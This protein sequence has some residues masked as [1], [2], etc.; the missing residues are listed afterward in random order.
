MMDNIVLIGGGGHCKSVI[1][2]LI[3]QDRYKIAAI[4]DRSENLGIK[5]CGIPIN[6]TDDDLRSLFKS[7]I[8]HAFITVGGL[9]DF[10]IRE[11]LYHKAIEIGFEFP[12]IAD[13][14]AV[15]SKFTI[16]ESG[17][18]IGKMCVV[19]SDAKIR[20]MA[21]VNTGTIVEHDCEIGSFSFLAPSVTLSG[22]VHIG[23]YSHIGTGTSIIH[24]VS[25][26]SNCLIG[27]G[28]TVVRSFGDNI[29]AFGNPCREVK[30]EKRN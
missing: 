23:D 28:S 18:F 17:T 7:G 24:N 26:G 13:P 11:K 22:G 8:R 4:V 20:K 29:K 12:V 27:A 16:V 6:K 10:S 3:R 30:N 25:I 9:G 15:I 19:N 14:S 5:I 2:V 1:D 21:I